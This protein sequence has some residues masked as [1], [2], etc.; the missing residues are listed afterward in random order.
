MRRAAQPL[1][2]GRDYNP[3]VRMEKSIGRSHGYMPTLRPRDQ[4]DCRLPP[5]GRPPLGSHVYLRCL[6]RRID[7]CCIKGTRGCLSSARS[8]C[9]M[10]ASLFSPRWQPQM[11][12]NLA[13]NIAP[14][15]RGRFT[16]PRFREGAGIR[17]TASICC[18]GRGTTSTR[19]VREFH[20]TKL[21]GA[22][23]SRA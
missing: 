3:Q 9:S 15:V 13:G 16:G 14:S 12:T 18:Y 1:G 7:Q 11:M 17:P 23:D 2:E 5:S 4:P 21:R 22:R 10:T 8:A 19:R 20:G 6:S